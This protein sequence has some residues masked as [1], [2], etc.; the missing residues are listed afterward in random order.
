MKKL[1]YVFSLLFFVSTLFIGCP[2]HNCPLEPSTKD[3]NNTSDTIITLPEDS[4]YNYVSEEYLKNYCPYDTGT[5]FLFVSEKEDR[6]DTLVLTLRI[7]KIERWFHRSDMLAPKH[8]TNLSNDNENDVCNISYDFEELYYF[9]NFDN[10]ALIIY[11]ETSAKLDVPNVMVDYSF[12]TSYSQGGSGGNYCECDCKEC[13]SET[14]FPHEIK[15]YD[16]NVE[17]KL[18]IVIEQGRGLT[19]FVDEHDNI[20]SLNSVIK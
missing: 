3:T 14:C 12:L 1:F 18:R 5:Q 6:I 13:V 4:L 20:W 8:N 16:V 7:N 15:M 2:P 11:I 17:D 9:I 10:L 19:L